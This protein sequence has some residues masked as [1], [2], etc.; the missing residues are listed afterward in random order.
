MDREFRHFDQQLE[1]LRT[2]LLEMSALV[3][4]AVR[5]SITAVVNRNRALAAEVLQDEARVNQ[6]HIAVDEQATSLLALRQPMA[7]D[8]RLITST[9]KIN[10]DLERIG[11]LAVNIVEEAIVIGLCARI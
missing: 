8:L 2:S 10:S 7:S 11:D 1:Q 9:L 4:S 5:R 6:M 3:E